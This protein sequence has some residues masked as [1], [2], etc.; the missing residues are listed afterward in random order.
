M[1]KQTTRLRDKRIQEVLHGWVCDID[2]N[3]R[4]F[5]LWRDRDMGLDLILVTSRL[6]KECPGLQKG[7]VYQDLEM[8]DVVYKVARYIA[9]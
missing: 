7:L 4:P 3:C 1:V 8:W 5:V 9:I 6:G 2:W